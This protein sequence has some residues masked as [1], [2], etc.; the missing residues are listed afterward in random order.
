MKNQKNFI[1]NLFEISFYIFYVI[2]LT[3]FI[4][5]IHFQNNSLS[6]FLNFPAIIIFLIMIQANLF[7]F[8]QEFFNKQY[9]NIY[10]LNA[11]ILIVLLYIDLNN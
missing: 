7:Y 1:E 2:T 9:K 6:E 3:F 8:H 5:K 4:N 11:A 10:L